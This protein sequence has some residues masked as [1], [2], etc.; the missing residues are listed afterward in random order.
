MPSPMDCA[1]FPRDT[2]TPPHTLA[3]WLEV[4]LTDP[5]SYLEILIAPTVRS[6]RGIQV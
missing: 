1:R 4:P 2:D 6:Q 3:V 5:G